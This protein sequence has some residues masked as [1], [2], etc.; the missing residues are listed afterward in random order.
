MAAP[1]WFAVRVEQPMYR[2][3]ILSIASFFVPIAIWCLV[4]YVPPFA[5][6]PDVILDISADR[7]DVETVYTNGDRVPKEHFP[8]FQQAIRDANAAV[9][10]ARETEESL[11]VGS[12]AQQKLLRHIAPLAINRGWLA[13]DQTR[14]DEAIYALWGALAGDAERLAT[15]S[16][17]NRE[18]IRANWSTMS[19]LSPT[20]DRKLLPP[21][22]LLKLVP[23]GRAANPVYLPA[24]HEVLSAAVHIFTMP[25]QN[26]APTMVER[27]IQSIGIVFGGFLMAALIGVP[28]GV[29]SGA[30]PAASRFFEPFIDFFRYMPAPSFATLLVAIFGAADAPKIALVFIG[31]F[32]QLVLVVSKTTRQLD[33]ALLEA[34]QTLGAN[35]RRLV[36]RVV[37][38]GILP[39]LYN[40]LRILLGWAWTWLVIAELIGVKS[41]LTEFIDTQGR[42]R[43]FDLVF[44][45]IIMIGLFGF[46]TD[47][48]LAFLRP[49]LFPW[50]GLQVGPVARGIWA[51]ISFPFRLPWMLL[52]RGR[53]ET[54]AS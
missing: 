52:R 5:W 22:A 21:E 30:F 7:D 48:I 36:T 14:D 46:I 49:F 41:G 37:I 8:V 29:V 11:E 28:I 40:D 53:P 9:R 34:A 15:F 32:F 50:L 19:A 12:R 23:Q 51:V 24:P 25:V 31:T 47:Q 54:K 39:N 10:A 20:Y 33:G 2:R 44:P 3:V 13:N 18:V 35:N 45:V 27:M 38:P 1:P 26:D 42:W 6:H 16:D 4:S 17:E 43:N